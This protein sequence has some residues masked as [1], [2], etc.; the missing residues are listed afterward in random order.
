MNKDEFVK[1]VKSIRV[2]ADNLI[3]MLD[4]KEAPASKPAKETEAT[5]EVTLEEVRAVLAK[6]AQAGHR[7]E[8]KAILTKHGAAKLSAVTDPTVLAMIKKEAEE[9]ADA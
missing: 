1:E 7:E 9:I 6:K 5:P 3:A 8:V 4:E 2:I